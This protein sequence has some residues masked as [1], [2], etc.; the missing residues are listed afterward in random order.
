MRIVRV[1]MVLKQGLRLDLGASA[2]GATAARWL[3]EEEATAVEAVA[4]DEG[5]SGELSEGEIV[6]GS[7]LGSGSG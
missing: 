3:T 7:G 4:D 5:E 6:L 1:R 2:V